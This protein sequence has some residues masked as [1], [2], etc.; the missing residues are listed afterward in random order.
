MTLVTSLICAEPPAAET[1]VPGR[2]SL[3]H[4][5]AHGL[6]FLFWSSARG[7]DAWVGLASDS[8]SSGKS[9]GTQSEAWE[10]SSFFLPLAD[11]S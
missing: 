6:Q 3:I 10:R 11:R 2:V 1:F 5:C 7:M 8:L 9:A 4:S